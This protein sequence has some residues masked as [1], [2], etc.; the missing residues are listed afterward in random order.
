M[1]MYVV[2]GRE[3]DYEA[4]TYVVGVYSTRQKAR[5]IINGIA[6]KTFPNDVFW[7]DVNEVDTFGWEKVGE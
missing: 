1:E 4:D 6:M 3:D 5:E 2:L 7:I